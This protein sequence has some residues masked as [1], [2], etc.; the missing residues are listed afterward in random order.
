[1][2]PRG[3]NF[4]VQFSSDARHFE[5]IPT[6]P[7]AAN[8]PGYYT[9]IPHVGLSLQSKTRSAHS[10]NLNGA[11]NDSL[12]PLNCG[13]R[14]RRANNGL[15][16][17]YAHP[18][19]TPKATWGAVGCCLGATVRADRMVLHRRGLLVCGLPPCA[20]K[21]RRGFTKRP[22]LRKHTGALNRRPPSFLSATLLTFGSFASNSQAE[23]RDAPH[24]PV[25]LATNTR[26]M[27]SER[28]VEIGKHHL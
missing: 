13:H 18:E 28:R 17:P 23:D 21:L 10:F 22:F 14:A 3:V 25:L 1:M 2:P 15:P 5:A 26:Q 20:G 7:A 6:A 12:E 24:I 19:G 8:T 16:Q 27:N 9:M 11:F 4:S